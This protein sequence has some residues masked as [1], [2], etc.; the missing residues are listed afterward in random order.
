MK[1]YYIDYPNC[2]VNITYWL[3]GSTTNSR[4]L[5][6]IPLPTAWPSLATKLD[7]TGKFIRRSTLS[8]SKDE[9]IAGY[10][11]Y[12]VEP[13][14]SLLPDPTTLSYVIEQAPHK[15]PSKNFKKRRAAGEILM[16]PYSRGRI[17]VN[18]EASYDFTPTQPLSVYTPSF[19][20]YMYGGDVPK[21]SG[22]ITAPHVS[23]LGVGAP[24]YGMQAG[25]SLRSVSVYLKYKTYQ[26]PHKTYDLSPEYVPLAIPTQYDKGLITAV[27]ADRNNGMYDL[28]SEL[29]EFPETLEFLTNQTKKAFFIAEATESDIEK[30]KGKVPT[31]IARYAARKWMMARYALLPIFYSIKDIKGALD[32]MGREYAEYKQISTSDSVDDFDSCNGAYTVSVSGTIVNRCFIKSRY[33]PDSILA[34][35][36]RLVN[37]NIFTSAWE[38][39]T[40]SFV[41]DWVLN[42]GDFI[43][44]LTGSD[45]SVDSKCCY[46]TRDR[47]QVTISYA[48]NG[49]K[50]P[51]TIVSFNCYSRTVINPADHIGL[52]LS[53]DMNWK[54]YID[55]SA[56]SLDPILKL[57]RSRK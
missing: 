19:G 6:S 16:N 22:G 15:V 29:G 49:S 2:V 18:R 36:R 17:T 13:G 38:L 42:V 20:W 7:P 52:D 39:A 23:T 8:L 25:E 37:I 35:F 45:G 55:A 24:V 28:L 51:K 44:A 57:I 54:R 53:W 30:M 43:S 10:S 40:R 48:I 5:S 11:V 41:V 14:D 4:T 26:T 12:C 27:L 56:M 32:S 31:R 1:W 50:R 34:D 3:A 47:R 33:T 9:A 21:W 46:S